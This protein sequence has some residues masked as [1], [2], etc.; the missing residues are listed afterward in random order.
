MTRRAWIRSI[1]CATILTAGL[2]LF[3]CQQTAPEASPTDSA[4]ILPGFKDATIELPEGQLHYVAGGQGPAL[5]LLH[6][7]PEDWSEWRRVAPLLAGRFTVIMPDLRGLGGSTT[8]SERFDPEAMASDIVLLMASRGIT[9]AYLVGHDIG[10]PVAYALARLQPRRV[11]GV[12]LV[13]APLQG[14][15]SWMKEQNSP[16]MWHVG[17]HQTAGLPEQLL[18][19]REDIYVRYFLKLSNGGRPP[20]E[21]DVARYAAAYR[22]PERL[23]ALLSIYRQLDKQ[24]AF[25]QAHTGPIGTP[26]AIVGGEHVFGPLVDG[27]AADLRDWGATHVE[28]VVVPNAGHYIADE[29]PQALA[30]LIATQAGAR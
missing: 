26:I 13:E 20:D 27:M 23:H 4:S 24:E 17:F 7:F 2:V 10:G 15:P 18:A 9:D 8:T 6:A 25:N 12:M 5:I 28:T 21:A 14:M 11:R 22:A 30:A 3:A 29:Q 1:A 19:G 16:L